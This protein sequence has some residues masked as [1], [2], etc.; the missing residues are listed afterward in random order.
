MI[1]RVGGE[2]EG[3]QGEGAQDRLRSGVAEHRDR[4]LRPIADPDPDPRHGIVHL[5]AIRQLERPLLFGN[6]AE[7]FQDVAGRPT[8]RRSRVD[9]RV[10]SDPARAVTVG[11]RDRVFESAHG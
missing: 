1:D 8:V 3:L 6:D 5:A 2:Q 4:R 10:H 7:L 9:Q 11:D